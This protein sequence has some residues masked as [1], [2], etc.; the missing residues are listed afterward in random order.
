MADQYHLKGRTGALIRDV[1]PGGAADK[2]GMRAGDLVVKINGESVAGWDQLVVAVR[3]VHVG[4]TVP[5]VVVRDGKEITLQ[6]T[7][8][9]K[10]P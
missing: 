1:D 6:V 2:A 8:T 5:V 4:Q 7:P 9:L 3:K 10:R